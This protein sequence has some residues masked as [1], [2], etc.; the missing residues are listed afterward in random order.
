M[1][2]KYS[3]NSQSTAVTAPKP[4][5]SPPATHGPTGSLTSSWP[6]AAVSRPQLTKWFASS[7]QPTV[8]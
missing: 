8:S 7:H 5:A 3:A 1:N 2:V 6:N 4:S